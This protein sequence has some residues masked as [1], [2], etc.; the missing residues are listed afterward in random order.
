MLK[1]L[2]DY[3]NFQLWSQECTIFYY[4]FV[5]HMYAQKS[6]F[7]NTYIHKYNLSD[8]SIMSFHNHYSIRLTFPVLDKNIKSLQ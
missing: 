8:Y 7:I 2:I 3:N 5:L 4:Y 1:K 6:I